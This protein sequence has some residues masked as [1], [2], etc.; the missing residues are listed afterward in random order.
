MNLSVKNE[1]LES[2]KNGFGKRFDKYVFLLFG[3]CSEIVFQLDAVL[4]IHHFLSALVK[5]R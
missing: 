4:S 2:L 5:L 1:A 3:A